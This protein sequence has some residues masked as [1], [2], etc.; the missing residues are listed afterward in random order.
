MIIENG[1]KQMRMGWKNSFIKG[2]ILNDDTILQNM[3]CRLDAEIPT[4]EELDKIDKKNMTRKEDEIFGEFEKKE[5]EIKEI[6]D[7]LWLV[8]EDCYGIKNN[9]L[10]T[11]ANNYD[12]L[13]RY[14]INIHTLL[15]SRQQEMEKF[16]NE[17]YAERKGRRGM[18][19][20][21]TSK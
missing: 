20:G 9:D 21:H 16:I 18:I 7:M 8:Y 13:E 2:V 11:K 3:Q 12:R 5:C 10:Y 17:V 19:Y 14:L 4:V 15:Y 1:I 6:T